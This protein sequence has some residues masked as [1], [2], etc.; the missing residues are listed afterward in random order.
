MAT[1]YELTDALSDDELDKIVFPIVVKPIDMSGNRSVSYYHT[2][3]EVIDVYKYTRSV[4]KSSKI[5]VE[6]MLHGKEL[7]S[8]YVFSNREI[9]LLTLNAMYTQPREPIFCHTVTS[10]VSIHVEP[11]IKDINPKIVEVLKRV[12]VK[13]SCLGT[14]HAR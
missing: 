14:D 11:Y 13:R 1:D 12:C 3:H 5:I 9:K 6:R 2:R 4:S 7:Y 8:S 10:T